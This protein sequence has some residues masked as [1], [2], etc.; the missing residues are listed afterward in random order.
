MLRLWLE[1]PTGWRMDEKARKLV[2][3]AQLEVGATPF[4]RLPWEMQSFVFD[5]LRCHHCDIT[6]SNCQEV[7][8]AIEARLLRGPFCYAHLPAILE[9]DLLFE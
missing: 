9:D 8:E 5:F 3:K 4:D 6:A 7:A 1:S 2:R